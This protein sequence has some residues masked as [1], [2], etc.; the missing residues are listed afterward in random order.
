MLVGEPGIGK[1]RTAE[2]LATIAAGCGA[3]VLWGRCPEERGAPPYWPW[4]QIIRSHITTSDANITRSELGPG[5]SVVAEVVSDIRGFWPD[6]ETPVPIDDPDAARFRLFDAISSFLRRMSQSR[7]VILILDNL[8]WSDEASLRFLEFVA[9]ELAEIPMLIVGTY[10]DVEI[11]RGHPL[12]RALGDLT[13]QRLF[14]RVLLRG[15]DE[16][17]VGQLIS[18]RAGLEPPTQLAQRIHLQTEGN[19]LFVEEMIHLMSS[20][21]IFRDEAFAPPDQW[22]FRLPEGVREVIGR[23]LDMLSQR[24][25]DV[26]TVGA[27]IGRRFELRQIAAA[28]EVESKMD[29]LEVL[30]EAVNARIIHELPDGADQ[31][32]FTHA[33]VQQT[34]AAELSATQT[35]RMHARVATA[36]EQLY[37]DEAN[38]HAQELFEHFVQAETVLGIEP[39]IRYATIAGSRALD[40]VD[41]ASA[42]IYLE[43]GVEAFGDNVPDERL[44]DLLAGLGRAQVSTLERA[45]M[46]T[47]IDNVT[48]AFDIYIQLENEEAAIRAAMTPMWSVHG[49]TG[50]ADLIERALARVEESSEEQARLLTEFGLWVSHERGDYEMAK[51]V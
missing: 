13:R 46:Q 18:A 38:D 4:V 8:H 42:L 37:V 27:V 16:E 30:E 22:K 44:A 49:P 19:P 11:A 47:A 36:L 24:A 6:L 50:R 21:G 39:V 5:A 28:A 14:S 20:E 51:E 17:E 7:P 31:Y 10:R 12:F 35:V 15:L 9:Q 45:E 43:A 40:A 3:E 23:R 33:L 29:L 1:T 2:E 32:E 41:P 34:I 48:R 26:L 25:N